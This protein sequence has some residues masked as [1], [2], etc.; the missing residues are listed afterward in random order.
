MA[1]I[2]ITSPKVKH[3]VDETLVPLYQ[4]QNTVKAVCDA[5]NTN[6]TRLGLTGSRVYPNRLHS[7]L[8]DNADA[9][10]NEKTLNT[11]LE[12]T[13]GLL[14]APEMAARIKKAQKRDVA[15]LARLPLQTQAGDLK[16]AV[17][18]ALG[19]PMAVAR[20][21]LAN[22]GLTTPSATPTSAPASSPH[23]PTASSVSRT[24][25]WSYQD[26]A[27]QRCI[28]ALK[29]GK[30]GAKVGAVMP[31]GTGKTRTALRLALRLL[32]AHP[33]GNVVWITHR[34]NLKEQAEKELRR[35]IS[36][37]SEIPPITSIKLLRERV[38]FLMVNRVEE[39]LADLDNPPL[40]AIID[41]AHHA[42][43]PSYQAIFDTPY[44]LSVL[45]LT[46][47]PNRTDALPIGI[48]EI[49]FTITFQEAAERGVVLLPKFE[50][51]PVEDFDWSEESI[52][53]LANHLL[54]EAEERF[55]KVLVIAPRIEKVE[56][57]YETLV[58]QLAEHEDHPLNIDDIGYVH[59]SGNSMGMSN[60]DFLDLYRSKP[61]AIYVSA[62][63]LLE[64]F[65][66]PSINT[67]VLTYPSSSV[68]LLMQAA[69]RCVRYAPDKTAAYVVQ[70]R[71]DKLAYHFENRW[72]YQEIS[73][74]LR[75]KIQDIT[76]RTPQ[77][78][79]D[80]VAL[81]LGDHRVSKR[82]RTHIATQVATLTPGQTCRLMLSGLAY[83]DEPDDFSSQATWSAILEHPENSVEF[84]TVFNDYCARGAD[85]NAH[86]AFLSLHSKRFGFS[87]SSSRTGVWRQ[88]ETLLLSMH[89]AQ[90]ELYKPGALHVEKHHRGFIPNG[91]STWLKY[92]TFHFEPSIPPEL[93]EFLRD[94]HN[95]EDTAARYLLAPEQIA[96]AIKVPI[97][98]GPQEAFL[99]QRQPADALQSTLT[100]LK[101]ALTETPPEQR[102]KVYAAEVAL[103]GADLP[104]PTAVVQR[105][106]WLLTSETRVL[107]LPPAPSPSRPDTPQS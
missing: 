38:E 22:Q 6:R 98:L 40:L 9:S 46:A 35:Q 17:S 66:D 85:L 47:T 10:I 76:Y 24:P 73:D 99:L 27:I 87:K 2:R 32:S 102:L 105:L 82:L 34:K 26:Q 4:V 59:G 65:D 42:A 92:I 19:C 50:D 53:D 107:P 15:R 29:V 49:A 5:L 55:T 58:R 77:D 41:E 60:S 101:A 20:V 83:F 67:V 80:K 48:D 95:A 33:T 97:P 69:G 13:K 44:P 3:L 68:V 62:Q 86:D 91:N 61:R 96:M 79:Q 51:F 100:S 12:S 21:L 89:A 75:P 43:A 63:L 54:S 23:H 30:G 28:T 90:Q 45:C 16:K 1:R 39:R 94:C 57:F 11:I 71:N 84:R 37:N 31:T 14:S 88:Y 103:L 25:D 74:Y 18:D 52:A 106:E 78:L 56:T 70:A 81:V 72:L 36:A 8:S 7:L 104:L 93:A 64:G